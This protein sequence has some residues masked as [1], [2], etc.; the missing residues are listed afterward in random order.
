MAPVKRIP[1]RDKLLRWQMVF[2]WVAQRPGLRREATLSVRDRFVLDCDMDLSTVAAATSLGWRLV[3]GS[4]DL[5]N[6]S[7][8]ND[9]LLRQVYD[10]NSWNAM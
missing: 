8:A 1:N 7:V 9:V 3:V 10:S 2:Q 6:K 4:D 5:L